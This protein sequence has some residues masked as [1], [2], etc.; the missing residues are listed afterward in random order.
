MGRRGEG[1]GS[2]PSVVVPWCLLVPLLR[3]LSRELSRTLKRKLN[4]KL[5]SILKRRLNMKLNRIILIFI[6]FVSMFLV[7]V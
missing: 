5:N 2:R 6:V 3:G 4:N 7:F 1:R